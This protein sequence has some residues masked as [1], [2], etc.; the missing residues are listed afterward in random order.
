MINVLKWWFSQFTLAGGGKGGGGAPP[1]PDYR[2]AAVEQAAASKEL[3]TGQTWANRPTL[4][5]PWGQMTWQAAAG[6]DPSTGQPI[7]SWTGNV[8]LTPEQQKA[9]DAQQRIQAGKSGAA[10]TLLGQATGGFKKEFDWAGMPKVPGSV[11]EA[12]KGA[13]GTMSQM[14]EPGR[15]QQRTALDA[16][17]L[18]MGVDP[19]SEQAKRQRA[20]LSEQFGQQDKG[21]MAQALSE[22]RAQV[23]TQGQIRQQAIAEEA[24]RR[25][26]SLN[27]LNALLTGQ[28]VSM[29][30]MPGFAQAQA[31]QAPNFLGAAQAQGQ[32]NQNQ[33]SMNQSSGP[34][35][36]S[37]IGT[38][39][40]IAGAAMMF[41]DRRLKRDIIAL[42]GG[43]YLFR[44]LWDSASRVGV[45]AQDVLKTKPDAVFVV[46]GYL[47]V[48]YGR[49]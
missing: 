5:T 22:G 17:L 35:I 41:S 14:L 10:E 21:M 23:G 48:D 29:P 30:Q 32:Y 26:M 25:G 39:G 43:L 20:G 31:G 11:E 37:M 3:A 16:K 15:T 7:T 6:V 40:S 45:M 1:A 42:G 12:Q 33:A 44:Y 36:G 49:L 19:N 24:Q 38:V 13:Y 4:N 18:A 2:G 46:N 8:N 27:E 9:L 34:D 28:Q 47:A